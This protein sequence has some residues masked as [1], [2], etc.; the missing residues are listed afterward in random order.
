MMN[1]MVTIIFQISDATPIIRLLIRVISDLKV[2]FNY[3][4]DLDEMFYT[5]QLKDGEYS[6]DIYFSNFWCHTYD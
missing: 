4:S 5:N 2:T 3:L 6:G 1:A